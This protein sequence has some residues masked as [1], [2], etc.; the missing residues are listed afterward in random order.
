MWSIKNFTG[1]APHPAPV[2]YSSSPGT[3][4][5]GAKACALS[6][7]NGRG[8][9]LCGKMVPLRVGLV[10][11]SRRSPDDQRC[12]PSPGLSQESANKVVRESQYLLLGS[13]AYV[14]GPPYT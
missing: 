5:S 2:P 13:R 6:P 12:Y 1:V 10:V 3:D 14:Q 7:A 4:P 11:G 8:V 9:G